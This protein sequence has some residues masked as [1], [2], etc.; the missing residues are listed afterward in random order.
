LNCVSITIMNPFNFDPEN[1]RYVLVH[2]EKYMG[3]IAVRIYH[4]KTFGLWFCFV[5]STSNVTKTILNYGNQI[6]K[7]M[8]VYSFISATLP[9]KHGV[10]HATA[11]LVLE[12]VSLP[13][14]N[15]LDYYAANI[16]SSQ[17]I[18]IDVGQVSSFLRYS[19]FEFVI[20]G[21]YFFPFQLSWQFGLHSIVV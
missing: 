10:Q 20:L 6:K 17:G 1:P 18:S 4:H 19:C 11:H 13:E 8:I 15:R 16:Y 5:E 7:Q 12:A 3:K 2:N 14:S 9:T 21:F